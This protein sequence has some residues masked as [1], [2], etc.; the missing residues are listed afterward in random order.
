MILLPFHTATKYGEKSD[1]WRYEILEQF[2][3]LYIDV[4]MQAL[5]SLEDL[6]YFYDFYIGIQSLDTTMVQLG[7]GI[8][9]SR[10]H[11]PLL[12]QCIQELKDTYFDGV[13]P[14][15]LRTGPLF[16]TKVFI[17]YAGGFGLHDIALPAS[18]FYPCG[19]EQKGEVY[20]NWITPESLAVHHWAGSW[21]SKEA[22][23][24]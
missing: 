4:D 10:A 24:K 22:F 1:I 18:Y 3:G 12:Q 19:Y 20:E 17:K 2:G 16:F 21:L 6:H 5:E 7:I 8:F 14:I 15:I 11:H 23:V 9:G 13:K